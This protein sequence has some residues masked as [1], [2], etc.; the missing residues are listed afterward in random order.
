MVYLQFSYVVP[1]YVPQVIF[2]DRKGVI[3]VQHGGGDDFFKDTELET[4]LRSQIESLL[5]EPQK[6]GTVR[7]FTDSDR[8]RR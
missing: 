5:K 6:P 1:L 8:P 7:S 2:V 3:R 4:N